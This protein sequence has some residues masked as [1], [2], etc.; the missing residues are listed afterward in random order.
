MKPAQY[1]AFIFESYEF[2][3]EQ[4]LLQLH[5]SLDGTLHFKETYRFQ[6]PFA[7]Y[8]PAVLDRALQS[9]FFM[10]GV[11]YY[12]TYLPT[13]IIIRQGRLDRGG[14]DFFSKT[15]QRGLGEFWYVNQLDPRTH[16]TFPV[17]AETL[18]AAPA[19]GLQGMLAGIGGGKDSL[20]TVEA[21]RTQPVAVT[22]WSLGHQAQLEP[23]I[24]RIGLP[25]AWIERTW[26]RQLL[27][28]NQQGAY[29]G[30]VPISAIIG[31]AGI[32]AAVL[33]GQRD[34]VVSNEQAANEPTLTYQGVP[35]NHQYS[36]SQEFERD[37][38]AYL[39]HLYGGGVRYY[40]FLRPL[41]ELRIAELFAANAFPRYHDV[42]SSC[43]R[44]FTHDSH[45]LFWCGECPKCAFVF[46]VLTPFLGRPQ[47]EA[48]WNGHN[49]LLDPALEST[50]RQLLG[51]EGDKP[52]E[53]VGEIKESRA[54]MR[55]CQQQYPE[56]AGKYQFE[57]P[58]DYDFRVL[59]SDEMPADVKPYFDQLSAGQQPG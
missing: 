26:D 3:P 56:L 38:Q 53:C 49:L 42:F 39:Q 13:E 44:A 40:S 36:K 15:Y 4:Q 33:G 43:N 1:Q 31:C 6:F 22:T 54:A 57:L 21:L 58:D 25:H 48:L 50:Y 9:L 35:I 24:A 27:D 8:D 51:I 47:L 32:V 29:N 10:A 55:L 23:L 2:Q 41:S 45:H 11:S 17:T 30:H 28:L 46:M 5:Y 14:A 16:V 18:P 7:A 37:F 19:H 12:K 34:V 59:G 20:L 52:L